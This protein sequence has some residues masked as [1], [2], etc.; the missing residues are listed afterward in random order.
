MI[1]KIENTKVIDER[2]MNME[3]FDTL[4]ESFPKIEN[5]TQLTLTL[6]IIKVFGNISLKSFSLSEKT[7]GVLLSFVINDDYPLSVKKYAL[8]YILDSLFLFP[9]LL[10]CSIELMEEHELEEESLLERLE[11]LL[12][13]D[14]SE[15]SLYIAY[16]LGRMVI[17]KRCYDNTEE[18]TA[19]LVNRY[20]SLNSIEPND[21]IEILTK[22]LHAFFVEMS[23][24]IENQ[25]A[26]S[27]TIIYIIVTYFELRKSKEIEL[28][29]QDL[30]YD[31]LSETSSVNTVRNDSEEKKQLSKVKRAVRFL[32][33]YV[34]DEM[35]DDII[36]LSIKNIENT[37]RV[38][39]PRSKL[40]TLLG[41]S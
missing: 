7:I 4:T 25:K 11:S 9:N 17:C 34:D 38:T 40:K 41:I 2:I 6:L 37:L 5:D 1:E 20:L 32:M 36:N 33:N 19:I 39:V 8:A 24:T 10:N 26:I 35:K 21:N 12:N 18:I 22:F 14:I 3:L 28:R 31:L 15:T 23:K 29:Y 16:G 30:E 13:D 27:N